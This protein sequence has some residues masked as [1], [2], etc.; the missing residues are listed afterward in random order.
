MISGANHIT[1]S[2]RDI[3]ES[4]AFYT[5]VLGFRPVAKWPLGAYLLAGDL[6]IAL[7]FDERLRA[8]VL[9]EYTH[10][11]FTVAPA[12][13]AALSA[14]I[15]AAGASIWQPNQTEG[16]SLYFL[17]PNGHKLEIHASDLQTR[18]RTAKEAPW[19]G[20]EFFV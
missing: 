3:E 14:R 17:D 10:I 16:D 5:T 15:V 20:L 2:I 4:F 1:L 8:A 13:F 6:W 11:A 9:P 18:I 19:A 12:D 7:V